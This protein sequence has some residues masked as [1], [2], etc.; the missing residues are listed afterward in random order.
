MP[1]PTVPDIAKQAGVGTAT[2]ERVLNG[3]GGVRPVTAER[4]V[5][6]ARALGYSRRLPDL[7]RGL[8]RID[9]ILVRP[10][11]TFFRRLSGAFERIGATLDPTAIPCLPSCRSRR[12]IMNVESA[13][14]NCSAGSSGVSA[15]S[16]R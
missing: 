10:E 11:T 6:A 9:V 13:R 8:L 2:V 15:S 14:S 1:K 16:S 12:A 7:H 3:R 4:V 5:A